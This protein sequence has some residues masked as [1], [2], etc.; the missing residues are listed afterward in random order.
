MEEN[1]AAGKIV[2]VTRGLKRPKRF[3]GIHDNYQGARGAFGGKLWSRHDHAWARGGSRHLTTISELVAH[4]SDGALAID[5]NARIV[6][7]NE[8]AQELLGYAPEDT[9]GR[10]CC[11]VMQAIVPSG[12]PLCGTDCE[13]ARCFERCVPYSV[14]A[15]QARHRDGHWVSLN[16][17]TIAVPVA[18]GRGSQDQ[19]MGVILLRAEQSAASDQDFEWPL[20]VYTFGRF[21]LVGAGAGIDIA[22]WPRRHAAILFKYLVAHLG[23]LVHRERLIEMLWPEADERQGRE[24]LKVTVYALRKGLRAA[25]VTTDVLETVGQSY[26]LKKS[27]IWVDREVYERLINQGSKL[28]RQKQH[29]E[30]IRCFEQAQRLYLGNYMSDEPYAD[31]CAED[32]ERLLEIHLDLLARLSRLYAGR[33]DYAKAAQSCRTAL[34]HEPCRESFH[35]TLMEILVR[36]GRAD[37]AI[38]QFHRCERLLAEQLGVEPM[39]ETCRLFDDIMAARDRKRAK[40]SGP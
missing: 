16:I 17:S 24:R 15:C 7:W 4:A 13:G 31:W 30:A 9:I 32:R 25:G 35:R 6:A 2:I 22:K 29:D 14:P 28:E 40:R 23:R 34:V 11:D 26:G 18:P 12:E 8:A 36:L 3:P 1:R 19:P 38:A 37:W 21:G 39:P 5:G 10:A 27:A 33:G 20:R